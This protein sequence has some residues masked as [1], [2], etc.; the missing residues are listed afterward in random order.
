MKERVSSFHL[1]PCFTSINYQSPKNICPQSLCFV[2]Y[3][4][5]DENTK[6][7][8][9]LSNRRS[10]PIGTPERNAE[11]QPSWLAVICL[12]QSSLV[13][14][15]LLILS[16][17]GVF[18]KKQGLAQLLRISIYFYFGSVCVSSL[19]SSKKQ[20]DEALINYPQLQA[21]ALPSA[22]TASSSILSENLLPAPQLL[23]SYSLVFYF[24]LCLCFLN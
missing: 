20:V 14:L 11:V 23:S 22:V 2:K 18:A 3:L 12:V 5:P 16:F 1:F 21:A 15:L 4:C 6:T 10:W 13:F 17:V 8:L 19:I 7:W 9:Q 24:P